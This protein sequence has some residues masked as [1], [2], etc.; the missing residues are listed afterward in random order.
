MQKSLKREAHLITKSAVET[1]HNEGPVRSLGQAPLTRSC[2]HERICV[3]TPSPCPLSAL[4]VPPPTEAR[5]R[6]LLLHGRDCRRPWLWSLPGRLCPGDGAAHRRCSAHGGRAAGGR[7][8]GRR[9]RP[10]RDDRVEGS[11]RAARESSYPGEARSRGKASMVEEALGWAS[12]RATRDRETGRA[13]SARSRSVA[14]RSLP[15]RW[16]NTRTQ[17]WQSL[18][19]TA[20][21]PTLGCMRMDPHE[22]SYRSIYSS[23]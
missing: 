14:P 13:A 17:G 20:R 9:L 16:S 10:L 19:A 1:R 3:W 18:P 7:M 5:A 8:G 23:L 22:M 15:E 21:L 12:R 6:R 11:P 4:R 2:H